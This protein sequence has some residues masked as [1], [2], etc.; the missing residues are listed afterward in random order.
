VI[1]AFVDFDRHQ[2]QSQ[3]LNIPLS[4]HLFQQFTKEPTI[5]LQISRNEFK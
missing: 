3:K 4:Y 2:L 5:R 1:A